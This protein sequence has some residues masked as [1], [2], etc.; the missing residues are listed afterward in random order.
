MSITL[1]YLT[2]TLIWGSTWFIISFQQEGAAQEVSVGLR[3][4]IAAALL[5]VWGY[6]AR[7]RLHVPRKDYHWVLMQGLLLF[8][9]NYLCVYYATPLITTGLIAVIFGLIIPFN[10]IH[11]RIFFGTPLSLNLM[12]SAVLGII[13]IGLVFSP[14]LAATT[15]D[16]DT[17]RGVGLS[18]FGAWLASLGNM[19]AVRNTRSQLPAVAINA[20]GMFWGGLTSLVIAAVAGRSFAIDWSFEYAA[21]LAYLALFGSAVAFGCYLYL[22]EKIG[23]GPAAYANIIVPIVA[24]IISTVFEGY[25]WTALAAVGVALVLGGNTLIIGRKNRQAVTRT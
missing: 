9:A 1:N 8:S 6:V 13:G 17:A 24:L 16:A 11:E 19:A 3:F 2:T 14:Q 10:M 23:S 20:H 4:L 12:G 21:S 18:V 22:I 25:E 5:V 15:F 7:R